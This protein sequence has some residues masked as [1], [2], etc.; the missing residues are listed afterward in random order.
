MRILHL[1]N[2]VKFYPTQITVLYLWKVNTVQWAVQYMSALS[3]EN[4]RIIG[5]VR[6]HRDT[7]WVKK[8]LL[9]EQLLYI[10]Y[11]RIVDIINS[12]RNYLNNSMIISIKSLNDRRGGIF[13]ANDKL[14]LLTV[15]SKNK[16][17]RGSLG[18]WKSPKSTPFLNIYD[19]Y[20][21]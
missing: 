17:K 21:H 12:S 6:A 1:P 3:Q 2:D 14:S 5:T 18:L 10:T 13:E 15:S 7:I 11:F 16:G 4:I 9:T 8:T 19:I 20:E